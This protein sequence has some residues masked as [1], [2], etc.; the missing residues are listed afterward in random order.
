VTIDE[1]WS[2]IERLYHAALERNP[3]ERAE[4]LRVRLCGA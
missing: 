4:F 2:E 1:R 3:D